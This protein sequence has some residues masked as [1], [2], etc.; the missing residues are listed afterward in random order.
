LDWQPIGTAPRNVRILVSTGHRVFIARAGS[1]R[2]FDDADHLIDRPA[3]WMP[4]PA[5]PSEPQPAPQTTAENQGSKNKA[6]RE[7]SLQV[8]SS[9]IGR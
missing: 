2:W 8:L 4:L 9:L 1:L 3:W 7:P 6:R 5:L